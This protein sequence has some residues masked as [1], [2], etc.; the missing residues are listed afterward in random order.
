M[1]GSELAI[2]LATS[3]EGVTI[4]LPGKVEPDPATGQLKTTFDDNPQ[5]PFSDFRLNFF[6]GPQ[7]VLRTPSACGTYTTTA[8]I[9]PWD[10]NPPTPASDSVA[11]DRGP[12]GTACPSGAFALEHF[13]AGTSNPLAGRYSP[14]LMGVA[15][16]TAAS[17]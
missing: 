8:A 12:G 10:G 3:A 15:G 11:I 4:K 16:R 6:G 2:Y 7:A 14:F 13:T 17:S 1:F 9:T 5:L